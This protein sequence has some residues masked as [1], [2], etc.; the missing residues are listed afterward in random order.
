MGVSESNARAD[1]L[2]ISICA[3]LLAEACNIGLE[4]LIKHQIPALTRHSLLISCLTILKFLSLLLI[5][6]STVYK[7]KL[8]TTT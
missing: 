8:D 4:P 3:V 5:G 1:E 2:P 7:I 6:R